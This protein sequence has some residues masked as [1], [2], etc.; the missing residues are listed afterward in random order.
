MKVHSDTECVA[1][2]AQV[3]R[4]EADLKAL[5]SHLDASL[6]SQARLEGEKAALRG[7]IDEAAG[8][9][10]EE[11]LRTRNLTVG[12]VAVGLRAA[13]SGD[14][15]G[16][17][18]GLPFNDL[19][20]AWVKAQ[21]EMV[22]GI[23][24]G[25]KAMKEGRVTPWEDVER[26]LGFGKGMEVREQAYTKASLVIGLLKTSWA[27]RRMPSAAARAIQEAEAALAALRG[28]DG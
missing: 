24:E 1:V 8:L 10:G 20:A 16:W 23:R 4:L 13:L 27:D 26:E 18:H 12:S 3:A 17:L 15:K 14:G 28:D 25:V 21:P 19:V 9:L 7:A 11:Y 5:N 6:E 2:D 22:A